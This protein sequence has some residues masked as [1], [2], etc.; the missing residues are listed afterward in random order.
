MLYYWT[1]VYNQ[2]A[3]D[4]WEVNSEEELLKQAKELYLDKQFDYGMCTHNTYL[5]FK[6]KEKKT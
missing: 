1:R 4:I 5:A 6:P 3:A 2:G